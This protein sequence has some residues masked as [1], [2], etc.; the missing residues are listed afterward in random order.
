MTHATRRSWASV[1]SSSWGNG[2]AT[3]YRGAARGARPRAATRSCS[4]SATCLGTRRI[5][6]CRSRISAS[7]RLYGTVADLDR[8]ARQIA[9]RRC[10]DRRLLC[11]RGAAVDRWLSARG[12]AVR[13]LRHRHAGHPRGAWRDGGA[14]TCRRRRSRGSTSI[15]RSPAARRWRAGARLRRPARARALL[16]GRPRAAP[17]GRRADSAGTSATSAPTARTAS[18]RWNAAARAGAPAAGPRASPSPGPLY[19][20]ESSWPANVERIEHLAPAEHPAFYCGARLDAE[21]HP[22]RH[23][24]AGYQPERAAVRGRPAAR[25]SC[26]ILGRGSRRSFCPGVTSWLRPIPMTCR[27][28]GDAT[29]HR[30]CDR[31][32]GRAPAR[33]HTAEIRAPRSWNASWKKPATRRVG[34]RDGG[35]SRCMRPQECKAVLVAR[36]GGLHGLSSLRG[37][38]G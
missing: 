13:V 7:S 3:T 35:R 9:Q 32:R 29:R 18:R 1:V 4:W 10:G 17:S 21:R 6:T 36:R 28:T 25:R 16:L 8:S 19:P 15:F 12:A 38:D 2:H 34:H 14:S 20:A 30:A 37:P 24:R 27:R 31:R 22:R 33:R 11:A 26:P 23:G 5:A